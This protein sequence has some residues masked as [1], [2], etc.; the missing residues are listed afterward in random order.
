MTRSFCYIADATIAFFT[1]LLK[2]DSFGAWNVS[3]KREESLSTLAKM[4]L[5]IDGKSSSNVIINYNTKVY[6]LNC[7]LF[8]FYPIKC[9]LLF[10]LLLML[11]NT[12][13]Y[14]K[15]IKKIITKINDENYTK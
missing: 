12:S 14:K 13:F 3:S 6:C 8:Y 1:V 5:D 2:A 10:T 11:I 7:Q 15:K 9:I 4:I